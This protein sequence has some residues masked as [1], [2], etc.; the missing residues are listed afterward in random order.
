MTVFDRYKDASTI[1]R[2]AFVWKGNVLEFLCLKWNPYS[3]VVFRTSRLIWVLFYIREVCCLWR[4]LTFVRVIN[5]FLV[6]V[7]PSC[8]RSAKMC[9]CQVR[10]L[11]GAARDTWHLFLGESCTLFIWT[12]G[13]GEAQARWGQKVWYYYMSSMTGYH[14]GGYEKSYLLWHN[15]V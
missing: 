3:R 4:V 12:G 14:C 5:T 7:I 2:E 11:Q 6:R 1:M 9:L 13:G 15:A 10:L 8:F